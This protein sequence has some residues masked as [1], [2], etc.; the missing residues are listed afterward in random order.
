MNDID[1]RLRRAAGEARAVAR[2][3]TRPPLPT[4]SGSP[5]GWLVFA[6]AFVAVALV[7][8]IPL[9]TGPE[10][11]QPG[12]GSTTPTTQ[13]ATPT[14]TTVPVTTTAPEVTCSATGVELPGPS[15]GLPPAVADTRQ[16]IIEA[17]GRCSFTELEAIAGELNTSFGGGGAENLEAWENE[18]HGE[19]GTLLKVLDMSHAVIETENS[20]RI[21]V[22]PAAFAHDLWEEIPEDQLDELRSLYTPEELEE[23]SVIGAYA[24]WRVGISENGDWM[25]FVAGD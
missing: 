7:G 9:L 16:A 14:T 6:A 8:I 11:I 13:L 25:F 5:R 21:F 2:R 17:A 19:L 18:D 3:K 1:Q 15:E 22:W 12:A 20:G 24:G 10:A 23:L 4:R